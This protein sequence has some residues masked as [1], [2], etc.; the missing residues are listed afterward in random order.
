MRTSRT[1]KQNN[2]PVRSFTIINSRADFDRNLI[3]WFFSPRADDDATPT[4][5]VFFFSGG[6]SDR[7]CRQRSCERLGMCTVPTTLAWS[8]PTSCRALFGIRISYRQLPR[9]WG[10]DDDDYD[11]DD[12]I[13]VQLDSVKWFVRHL[14]WYFVIS[15]IHALVMLKIVGYNKYDA[16]VQPTSC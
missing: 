5:F 10:D 14:D 4:R 16:T 7:H 15:F 12:T 11:G 8:W 2:W 1:H 6:G 13:H 9:R 3:F